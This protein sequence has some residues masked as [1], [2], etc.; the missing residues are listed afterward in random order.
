MDEMFKVVKKDQPADELATSQSPLE[1]AETKV[2]S[3]IKDDINNNSIML[4]MKGEPD[5]PQCGFSATMV[6]ILEQLEFDYAT[7]D[8]LE[9][10]A[11]RAAIKQF[12]D[13][14]T[15]PQLYVKGE[16]IGGCDIISDLHA[17][18]ELRPLLEKALAK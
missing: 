9:D 12:S 2:I 10:Q 4:Y 1:K 7:R 11:L 8:V 13:W 17:K 6:E 16:F 14:P 3:V 18:G 15:V 5:C